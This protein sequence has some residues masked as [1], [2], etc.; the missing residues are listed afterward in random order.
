MRLSA[1]FREAV[2]VKRLSPDQRVAE[3]LGRALTEAR[4]CRDTQAANSSD[5]AKLG[6]IKLVVVSDKHMGA[7]TN[8]DAFRQCADNYCAALGYYLENEY[9][10]L[11][12]G[13]SEELW[14]ETFARIETQ[15]GHVMDLESEFALKGRLLK[16]FGNHDHVWRDMQTARKNLSSRFGEIRIRESF[17]LQVMDGKNTI[18]EVFFAHG[19]QGDLMSDYLT[20]FSK[21]W[22]RPFGWLQANLPIP[23]AKPP[24]TPS[25]SEELRHAQDK[26]LFSWSDSLPRSPG[27]SSDPE[28]PPVVLIAGH[29]HRPVFSVPRSRERLIEEAQA[30]LDEARGQDGTDA[31]LARAELERVKSTQ[32][33]VPTD[34]VVPLCQ[35]S[36]KFPTSDH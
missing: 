34:A 16:F 19:H 28:Q 13:D 35:G 21:F 18:G 14:E 29:T 3:R 36:A 4:A 26:A 7:G 32:A 25:M 1:Q 8:S 17:L 15:Y 24:A 6:K 11:V 12:L 27:N 30:S 31:G 2:R 22:V 20:E 9:Q 33:N 23:W 5:S 10:L